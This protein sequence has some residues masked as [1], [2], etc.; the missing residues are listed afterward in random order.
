MPG[1]VRAHTEHQVLGGNKEHSQSKNAPLPLA[2]ISFVA[3][4]VG[5][6]KSWGTLQGNPR[7]QNYFHNSV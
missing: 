7:D 2:F 1:Q 4:C 5:S 6:V 3:L